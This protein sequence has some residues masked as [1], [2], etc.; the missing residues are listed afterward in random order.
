[1]SEEDRLYGTVNY[2]LSSTLSNPEILG[3]E[4]D[5]LHLLAQIRGR[6]YK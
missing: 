4:A 3:L 2:A 6:R 1:M 5:M